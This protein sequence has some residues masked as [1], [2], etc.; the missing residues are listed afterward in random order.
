MQ[1]LN[2]DKDEPVQTELSADDTASIPSNYITR[3]TWMDYESKE[4]LLWPGTLIH[5][6]KILNCKTR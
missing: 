4:A 5:L 6:S 3:K 1:D 2:S